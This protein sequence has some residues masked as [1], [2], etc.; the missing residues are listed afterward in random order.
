MKTTPEIG[1]ES[2]AGNDSGLQAWLF[3]PPDELIRRGAV[4]AVGSIYSI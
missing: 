1:V 2:S 3:A 4:A